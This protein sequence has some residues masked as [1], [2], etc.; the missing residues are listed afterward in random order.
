VDIDRDL[1]NA[2]HDTRTG[3]HAT[4]DNPH[5]ARCIAAKAR[6]NVAAR[7]D[8]LAGIYGGIEADLDNL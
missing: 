8:R 1:M 6:E 5:C 3:R 4:N 7:T 2:K